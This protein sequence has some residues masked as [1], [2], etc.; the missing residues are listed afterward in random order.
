MGLGS[1]AESRT[2]SPFGVGEQERL[3]LAREVAESHRRMKAARRI[4]DL[5]AEKY[6]IHIDGSSGGQWAEIIDNNFVA[7]RPSLVA[8]LR[9]QRNLLRPMTDNM[10]AYHCSIPYRAVVRSAGDKKSRDQAKV[11]ELLANHFILTQNLNECAADALAVGAAYG[12]GLLQVQW[13]DDLTEDFREPI[14]NTDLPEGLREAMVPGYADLL[15]GDPW[16]TVYSEGSSR[17]SLYWYSYERV[18]PTDF[19]REAFAHVPGI[20]RLQG[21]TDLPSASRHQRMLRRWFGGQQAFGGAAIEAGRQGQELTGIICREIIPGTDSRYPNGAQIIVALNGQADPDASREGGILGQAIPLHIGDLPGRRPSHTR[22]YTGF[23]GDDILGKGYVEDLDDLQVQLNGLVTMRAEFLRRFSRPPLVARAGSLEDD[24][25]TTEDDAIIYSHSEQAPAFL[26]PPTGGMQFFDAAIAETLE[27]MFRIGGWQAASRGE[28]NAGDPAA[29]VVALARADDTVF[30]P[31]AR[32]FQGALVEVLQT[33]H[34]LAKQ[35]MTVPVMARLL[36]EEWGHLS[37]PWIRAEKLSPEPPQFQLVQG[38]GTTP[39]AKAQQLI[40]MATTQGA[41]G[42][43][44]LTVEDFWRLWPDN[45]TRP[46]DQSAKRVRETR[47]QAINEEIER[48]VDEAKQVYAEQAQMVLPQLHNDLSLRFPLLR[49]DVP[50]LHTEV[51][52]QIVQNEYADP[53]ARQLARWRQDMYFDFQNM[54]AQQ[55]AAFSAAR[56]QPAGGSTPS[57]NQKSNIAGGDTAAGTFTSES[58]SPQTLAP[59]VNALSNSAAKGQL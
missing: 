22:V 39:E 51:L 42:T 26:Y 45:S 52:D 4:R 57:E 13:R 44:L 19:L 11:S 23:R 14:Y 9:L 59:T 53:L 7:V 37:D 28:S 58:M 16:G 30:A 20:D 6:A 43:P 40:T 25:V 47:A 41:D 2:F 24:T 27:Q 32:A 17:R 35:F 15:L 29:K 56:Q 3:S 55:G 46:P 10:I 34:M 33:Q 54:I 21:R 12:H 50:Q 1:P 5:T 31:T 38:F 49:T 36:G 48:V 8:R 18:F